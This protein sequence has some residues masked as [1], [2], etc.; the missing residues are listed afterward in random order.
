MSETS[1]KKKLWPLAD[2]RTNKGAD[3]RL[4][5]G[6]GVLAAAEA[7]M[8]IEGHMDLCLWLQGD[9]QQFLPHEVLI[10]AWGDFAADS[11]SFDVI[12]PLSP[13]RTETLYV[14]GNSNISAIES[15]RKSAKMASDKKCGPLPFLKNLRNRWHEIGCTPYTVIREADDPS[16]IDFICPQCHTESADVLSRMRSSLVH[17]FSDQRGNLEC[18][19]VFLSAQDLSDPVFHRSLRFFMPYLDHSMR[20]VAHLPVQAV[21]Q[22][23]VASERDYADEPSTLSPRESEIMHWVRVGKTN[24]EIGIILNISAFTVKN[25][26]QRIFKKLGTSSRAQTVDKLRHSPDGN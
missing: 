5:E 18:I 14:L 21:A 6:L 13:L 23:S 2:R 3:R 20:Q 10:A 26:L 25:H 4:N 7:S 8:R 17:G 15:C 19:Y 12:S 1:T 9:V 22:A 16:V 11:I 24:Y